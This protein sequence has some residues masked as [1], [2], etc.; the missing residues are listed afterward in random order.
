MKLTEKQHQFVLSWGSLGSQWGLNKTLAQIHGLFLIT[1]EAISMEDIME[2]LMISRGNVNMNIRTL[3]DWGIIY[4]ISKMGER[5]EYYIGE[6]DM[7]LLLKRVLKVRKERELDPML[8]L[9]SD[10]KINGFETEN[11][12][13]IERIS[14]IET[15]AK[16]AD[17]MLALFLSMDDSNDFFKYSQF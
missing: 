2:V 13:F 17:S 14:S 11:N 10:I 1:E 4:R 9:I 3:I 16:Q 7:W 6:K 12:L 5:R 15:F 8:K